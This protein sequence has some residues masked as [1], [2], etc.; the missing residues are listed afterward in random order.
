MHDDLILTYSQNQNGVLEGVHGDMT[1]SGVSAR[2]TRVDKQYL[3]ALNRGGVCACL[4]RKSGVST[5]LG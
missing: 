4:A 2:Q 1:D 5:F 3:A